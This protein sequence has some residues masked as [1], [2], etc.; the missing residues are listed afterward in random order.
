VRLIRS[1]ISE[2]CSAVLRAYED[3]GAEGGSTTHER[4]KDLVDALLEVARAEVGLQRCNWN[5]WISICY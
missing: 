1:H 4:V 5:R 3:G 2:T